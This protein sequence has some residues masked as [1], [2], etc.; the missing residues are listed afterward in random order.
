MAAAAVEAAAVAVAR[1]LTNGR[2]RQSLVHNPTLRF[3]AWNIL[4]GGGQRAHQ[5]LR[6]LLAWQ[7]DIIGLCEF[8]A[9]PASRWLAAELA[10]AG[11]E[12]QLD[13]CNPKSPAT[14]ALLLASRYPLETVKLR[15][16]PKIPERWLLTRVA[17]RPV[18][19]LGLMHV[20]NYTHP[21]LK[22]PFLT[23]VLKLARTWKLGPALLMGDTNCGKRELDE[24]NPQ[25]P[26]FQR[27]HD[28]IVN[29]EGCGW[30]DGFR[31]LHGARR[32]F[33]WYSHRDNGFRLD[34][35]FCSPDLEPAI[36]R[37]QHVWAEHD[38]QPQRRAAVSDHAALIVDFDTDR[39]R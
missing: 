29:M 12:H 15:G 31:R 36:E 30:A 1:P 3:V 20:P 35:A 11:Y 16:R 18:V 4:A 9:T 21:H 13:S 26:K 37:A 10:A 25:G 34:Y 27:E 33:S 19:T 14:N 7:P 28:W 22:Y 2:E 8:R 6:H 39:I 24:E 23:A 38:E 5:I 32:E 17:T